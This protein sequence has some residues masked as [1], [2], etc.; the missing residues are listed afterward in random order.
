MK[1]APYYWLCQL[2]GWGLVSL[3]NFLIQLLANNFSLLQQLV[4]NLLF[5]LLGIVCSHGLRSFYRYFHI[6]QRTL[7]AMILPWL[8]GAALA[9]VVALAVTF[10]GLSVVL[11]ADELADLLSLRNLLANLIGV[12]PLM[13]I[14]G[15]LYLGVHY[16]W[17]WREAAQ[18]KAQLEAALHQAQ[19]NTL[20]GQINPHFM[21][22]ALNNIRALMLE[23]VPK[24]RQ[25]LTLLSKVLR[26]SLSSPQQR[27]VP[28]SEELAVVED[29]VALASLQY[30]QR[31]QWQPQVDPACLPVL[32]PPM[33]VQTLVENAIKH[34]IAQT[35]GGGVLQLSLQLQPPFVVL[36]VSNPGQ[37]ATDLLQPNSSNPSSPDPRLSYSGAA[38]EHAAELTGDLG[39]TGIGVAN[40]RQRLALLY[41]GRADF[42]LSQ[43]GALVVAQ[44]H[45]PL[46][47]TNKIGEESH[48]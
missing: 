44:V 24:A 3:S 42:Q 11:Q 41:Q 7:G 31:L 6:E 8:S 10:A 2:I 33:L 26:A 15:S 46:H 36:T 19:L 1:T 37:L 23:D 13:L 20:L 40:V 17:H 35:P 48:G 12:Y 43:Q 22:N 38:L 29:F 9:T 45:L 21:F 32:V 39:S 16:L 27:F 47:T 25:A 28:L 18:Q 34:G 4:S 5:M 30:E 14:W